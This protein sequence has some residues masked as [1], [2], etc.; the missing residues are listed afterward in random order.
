MC[1]VSKWNF[2]R[3]TKEDIICYK[4]LII[5]TDKY[6]TPFTCT[7]VELNKLL[8]A[9]GIGFCNIISGNY[10]TS[11]YIHAYTKPLM[12]RSGIVVKAIIPKG[13]KYHISRDDIEICARKMFITDIEVKYYD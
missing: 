5:K 8:N 4:R 2:P 7:P 3:K 12:F 10:K 6:Y 9:K 13:T 11:R 1:L